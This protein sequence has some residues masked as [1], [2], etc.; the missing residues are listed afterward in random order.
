MKNIFFYALVI[1]LFFVSSCSQEP[2]DYKE[3]CRNGDYEAAMRFLDELEKAAEQAEREVP[4]YN[5]GFL[6]FFGNKEEYDNAVHKAKSAREKYEKAE[7]YID[8]S[9]S[10][11]DI[12]VT[13]YMQ[14]VANE[15]FD[16]A[17]KSLEKLYSLY[18]SQ[19]SKGESLR[20]WGST[21]YSFDDESEKMQKRESQRAGD[22]IITAADNYTKAAAFILCAEVRY[23]IS[24]Q[25]ETVNDRIVYLFNELSSVGDRREDGADCSWYG[26]EGVNKKLLEKYIACN[27]QIA[28]VVLDLA[29]SAGNKKL[30]AIGLSHIMKTISSNSNKSY[31]FDTVA[32]DEAQAKF[33]EAVKNGLL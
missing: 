14:A 22:N 18:I 5:E 13:D 7:A 16:Q 26:A 27:N 29:I 33:D 10:K 1:I 11:K 32:K 21:I 23:L 2:R 25:D 20:E 31:K 28:I 19:I 3:A 17:H 4:E 30:A 15:D 9:F 6:G 24:L 8:D 12:P